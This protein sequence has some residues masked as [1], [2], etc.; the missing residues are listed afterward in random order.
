MWLSFKSRSGFIFTL[1]K[2]IECWRTLGNIHIHQLVYP[3]QNPN[4]APGVEDSLFNQLINFQTKLFTQNPNHASIEHLKLFSAMTSKTTFGAEQHLA[5][6]L[7][8]VNIWNSL[9]NNRR[10]RRGRRN[11]HRNYG[12]NCC[13]YGW[14]CFRLRLFQK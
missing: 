1:E 4:H 2:I 13:S 14:R 3:W 6:S 8:H 10:L 12:L 9:R 11:G 5:V 7:R